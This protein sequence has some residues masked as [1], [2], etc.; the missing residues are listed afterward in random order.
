MGS[1]QC[2]FW[3][4]SERSV[5]MSHYCY[6]MEL[7]LYNKL[8]LFFHEMYPVEQ[9]SWLMI[10]VRRVDVAQVFLGDK[11]WVPSTYLVHTGMGRALPLCTACSVFVLNNNS[12]IKVGLLNSD[13]L[14][15]ILDCFLFFSFSPFLVP[16]EKVAVD[17]V[18][19]KSM[20][21]VRAQE[22]K[23]LQNAHFCMSWLSAPCPLFVGRI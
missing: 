13:F 3:E 19:H 9:T 16:C 10:W 2:Q 23:W 14:L 22:I 5:S 20:Y 11:E 15:C 18:P 7:R 12:K 1:Q 4:G 21:A 17:Q 8:L 6:Y